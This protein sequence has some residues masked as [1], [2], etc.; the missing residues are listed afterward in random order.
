MA[1]KA[2]HKVRSRREGFSAAER[3]GLMNAIS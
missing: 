1:S 3:L 2:A